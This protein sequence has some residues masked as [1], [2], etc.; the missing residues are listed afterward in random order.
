VYNVIGTEYKSRKLYEKGIPFRYWARMME[1][2]KLKDEHFSEI[3]KSLR[4]FVNIFLNNNNLKIHRAERYKQDDVGK[5]LWI[6]NCDTH[7]GVLIAQAKYKKCDYFI[8][9]DHRLVS[10]MRNNKLGIK[11]CHC[12]TFL[13]ENS[14]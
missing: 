7:D 13:R 5:L 6:Y 11:V 4:N 8:T 12:E 9:E 14:L 2:I 3:D 1:E 10:K